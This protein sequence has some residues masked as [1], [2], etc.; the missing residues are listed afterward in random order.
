MQTFL[1]SSVDPFASMF[2]GISDYN[3]CFH[4]PVNFVDPD[5]IA[6]NLVYNEEGE[7]IGNTE[8]GFEGETLIYSLSLWA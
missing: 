7:Y 4:N 1:L 5:G 3:Y 2:P 6:A 8:E